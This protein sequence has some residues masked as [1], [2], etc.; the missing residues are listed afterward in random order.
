MNSSRQVSTLPMKNLR[1]TFEMMPQKRLDRTDTY[2]ELRPDS[3]C[4]S[5]FDS[6]SEIKRVPSSGWSYENDHALSQAVNKLV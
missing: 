2:E 1:A 5:I 3:N 4:S 6:L